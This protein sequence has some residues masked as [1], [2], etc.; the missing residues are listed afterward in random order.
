MASTANSRIGWAGFFA[1]RLHCGF[2]SRGHEKRVP[3]LPGWYRF[4]MASSNT[5]NPINHKSP[6]S[7]LVIDLERWYLLAW[8][9][10]AR[11]QR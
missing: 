6:K 9:I 1:H 7:V 11:M 2:V 3:T 8:E 10:Q 4:V 5:S